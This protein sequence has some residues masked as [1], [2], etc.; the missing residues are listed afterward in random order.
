MPTDV[1]IMAR[2]TVRQQQAVAIRPQEG[3]AGMPAW[4]K[5]A[6][7][8]RGASDGFPVPVEEAGQP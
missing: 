3:A 1:E 8:A 4:H 2:I 7:T 6:I 5:A